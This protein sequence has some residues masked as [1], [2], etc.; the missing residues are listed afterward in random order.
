MGGEVGELESSGSCEAGKLGSPLPPPTQTVSDQPETTPCSCG[1][2][3]GSGEHPTL[4]CTMR[5]RDS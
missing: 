5:L 2:G 1:C 3:W 4:R